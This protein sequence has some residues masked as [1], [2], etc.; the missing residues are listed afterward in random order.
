MELPGRKYWIKHKK[1]VI[2]TRS[3]N[4]QYESFTK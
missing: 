3:K 2:S 4:K 1:T